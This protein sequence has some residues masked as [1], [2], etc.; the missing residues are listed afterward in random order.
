MSK[1]NDQMTISEA[2]KDVTQ[3]FEMMSETIRSSSFFKLTVD[4]SGI[5]GA[6]TGIMALQKNIEG[7]IKL[8]TKL[9]I[10]KIFKFFYITIF[11]ITDS[12]I[13]RIRSFAYVWSLN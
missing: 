12:L 4:V 1:N 7:I 13:S 9:F 6:L 10:I 5:I 3:T 2:F 11:I 8:L